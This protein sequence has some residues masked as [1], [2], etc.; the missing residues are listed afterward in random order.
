MRCDEEERESDRDCAR[1]E[2]QM[3]LELGTLNICT[4]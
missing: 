4:P 2:Y 1:W 3:G